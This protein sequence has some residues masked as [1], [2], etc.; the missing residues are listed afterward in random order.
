MSD[1]TNEMA[2][3]N[4]VWHLLPIAMLLFFMSLLDRTNISF[5]SLEMNGFPPA[6]RPQNWI[7]FG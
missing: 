3:R 6:L 2:V 1:H 4:V 7:A 5:A